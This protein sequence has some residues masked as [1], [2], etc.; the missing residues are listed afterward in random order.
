L[1]FEQKNIIEACGKS[2]FSRGQEYFKSGR[3]LSLDYDAIKGGVELISRTLGS[4]GNIYNQTVF[5]DFQG[6]YIEIDGQCDCPVTYNCKHIVAACLEY[7]TEIETPSL[8][9]IPVAK[10][11]VLAQGKVSRW[12]QNLSESAIDYRSPMAQKTQDW[13]IFI[14]SIRH[15][16]QSLLKPRELS[17]SIRA[18]HQRKNGKG[19]VKGREIALHNIDDRH[20]DF[21]ALPI[22]CDIT[23]FLQTTT[24][25]I[26]GI[27][28]QLSAAEPVHPHLR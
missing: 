24:E 8:P 9:P 22:D 19:L 25:Y 10:P 28:P 27:H 15:D 11:E 23:A 26:T 1:K 20:N 12:L 5:L 16:N 2:S 4:G 7:K 17:V 14:L 13:L 6:G 18:T 3:V 21:H